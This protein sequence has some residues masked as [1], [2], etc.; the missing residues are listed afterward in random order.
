LNKHA[1]AFVEEFGD[2][3]FRHSE[4]LFAGLGDDTIRFRTSVGGGTPISEL[5]HIYG[6]RLK[7][8]ETK[9]MAADYE[10]FIGAMENHP[11]GRCDMW[12]FEEPGAARYLVFAES[13]ERRVLGC[14]KLPAAK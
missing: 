5:I 4:R 8:A 13:A 14:L 11:D 9:D 7:M 12:Q 10:T 1:K 3:E 2:Q 6:V